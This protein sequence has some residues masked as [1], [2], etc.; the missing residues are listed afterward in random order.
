M[1]N[2][3]RS[4][5]IKGPPYNPLICHPTAFY[6]NIIDLDTNKFQVTH[7]INQRLTSNHQRAGSFYVKK[8]G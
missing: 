7:Q 4:Y 8:E 3:S 6:G 2:L 5:L 1:R